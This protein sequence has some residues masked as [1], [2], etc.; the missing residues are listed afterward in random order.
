M[1]PV[2]EHRGGWVSFPIMTT[3]PNPV[4]RI[5]RELLTQRP[6]FVGVDGHGASHFW[7]GYEFAVA[8]VPRDAETIADAERYELAE[9]PIDT[10]AQWCEHTC[11]Q[12]GWD[13][14]P[15]AGGTIIDDLRE[16]LA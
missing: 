15:H 3:Q 10:L 13:V 6:L 5:G 9:T 1:A 11:T 7:D 16:I 4:E 2:L 14:G 8:V 12:R